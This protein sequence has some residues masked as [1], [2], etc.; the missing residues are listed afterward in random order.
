MSCR[1]LFYSYS[2]QFEQTFF[3]SLKNCIQNL[4]LAL[5]IAASVLAEWH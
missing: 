3:H 4:K 2:L 1:V 5:Y